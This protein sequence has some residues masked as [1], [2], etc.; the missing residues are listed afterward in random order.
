M[1]RWA[2]A[3]FYLDLAKNVVDISS[4][5]HFILL[6]KFRVVTLR[7]VHV[8]HVKSWLTA[9]R[10]V[11]SSLL[12]VAPFRAFLPSTRWTDQLPPEDGLDNHSNALPYTR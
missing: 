10:K 7:F 12:P 6:M 5:I 11:C 4:V 9:A 2:S 8:L 1:L 3:E